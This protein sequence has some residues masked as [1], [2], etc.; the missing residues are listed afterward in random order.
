[1]VKA[2]EKAIHLVIV[3]ENHLAFQKA[4]RIPLTAE[5][6]VHDQESRHHDPEVANPPI[7]NRGLIA[8]T[9]NQ[10]SHA[11]RQ[12]VFQKAA[13][14]LH[15]QEVAKISI[16]AEIAPN[17]N[18][19][20]AV[21]TISLNLPVSRRHVQV[22]ATN[23]Q[24]H[25]LLVLAAKERILIPAKA[26]TPRDRM[27]GRNVNHA[28][29]VTTINP[30]LHVSHQ[31]VQEEATNAQHHVQLVQVDHGRILIL[32][33]V[34]VRDSTT[35]RNVNRVSAAMTNNRNSHENHRQDIKTLTINRRTGQHAPEKTMILRNPIRGKN[36]EARATANTKTQKANSKHRLLSMI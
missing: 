9:I 33:K 26:G 29:A 25:A 2:P 35:V 28:S 27:T 8:T 21:M 31:H 20:S 3:V 17:A 18:L 10:N 19:V 30:S 24:H 32:A 15:V 34:A 16:P 11:N 4:D 22:A 12:R 14:M 1:V 36:S 23:A 5:A 7:A 6:K 13:T